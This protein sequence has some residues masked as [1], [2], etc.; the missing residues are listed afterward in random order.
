LILGIFARTFE[1]PEME[2][3]L[4]AVQAHGLQAVQFNMASAGLPSM[5]NEIDPGLAAGIRAALAARGLEMA[6]VSGTFNMIHPDPRHR[7]EGLRRLAVLGAACRAMGTSTI[8][9]CT[10]TRD[11]HDKWRRHP[12]NALPDAWQ[13]LRAAMEHALAV[14]EAHD[15]TLGVEPEQ[16]N[17]VSSAESARRLLDEM[18]SPRLKVILDPVNLQAAGGEADRMRARLEEALDLLGPDLVAAH[19]KELFPGGAG[20]QLDYGHYVGALRSAGFRG[21]L[22]LHNLPEAAVGRAVDLLR[23]L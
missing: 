12:G 16:G 8:T 6:A 22:L 1:R 10:G 19:A 11:P 13:D 17:V 21:P 7:E 14:A 3:V 5:P 9:L 2:E 18:R 23:S 4:D 20:W 15:L